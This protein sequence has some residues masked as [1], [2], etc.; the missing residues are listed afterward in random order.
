VADRL[1]STEM[2]IRIANGGVNMP[3]FAGMLT[4]DEVDRLVAFLQTRHR[5]GPDWIGVR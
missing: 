4:P 5:P 1:G 2:I 3:A